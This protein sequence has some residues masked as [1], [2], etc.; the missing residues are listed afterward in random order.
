MNVN[1]YPTVD[2]NDRHIIKKRRSNEKLN[3]NV[4]EETDPFYM[5][6]NS[7]P[8]KKE[9]ERQ[10]RSKMSRSILEL[11]S[12]LP[13]NEKKK[14]TQTVIISD[15]VDYII[16]L[17]DRLKLIEAQN[18]KMKHNIEYL[19]QKNSFENNSNN[20]NCQQVKSSGVEDCSTLNG[21]VGNSKV[22][23]QSV[24]EE[25]FNNDVFI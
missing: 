2:I 18:V 21:T 11:K 1:Y 6:E 14:M 17:K 5:D 4:L 10:R 20:Q 12:L 24:L 16:F 9:K 15:S 25:F 13:T 19:E 7:S 23:Y 22:L 8:D 3:C